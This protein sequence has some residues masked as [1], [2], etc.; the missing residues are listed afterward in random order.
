MPKIV[1]DALFWNAEQQTYIFR[2]ANQAHLIPIADT[3][4]TRLLAPLK[5]FSFHGQY[6]HL[7]VRREV[8]STREDYWYAYR[9]QKKRTFKRYV[10]RS[11]ELSVAQLENIARAL[12]ID[13]QNASALSNPARSLIQYQPTPL[14]T[15]STQ[16]HIPLL[17]AKLHFPRLALALVSRPRLLALLDQGRTSPLTLLSAPAGTGKTTLV[18]QWIEDRHIPNIAWISLDAGDNDPARFWR[19]LITACQSF[20]P[21]LGHEALSQLM[22]Y[23]PL[24][25]F[26]TLEAALTTFLNELVA[27]PVNCILVLEDYHL[28]NEPRIHETVTFFLEHLPP[29]LHVLLLSRTEPPL[30]LARLRAKG[31]LFEITANDLRFSTEEAQSFLQQITPHPL[32][33][34]EVQ[35]LNIRLE[36]WATGLRLFALAL[37]RCTTR[38]EISR[39]L[40]TFTGN[41]RPLQDY[42][43]SEVLEALPEPLQVFLLSTS[44][45]E[46]ATSSLCD[47]VTDRTD[48]A[49][50]L[51][52][53][54]RYGLF[55]ERLDE[56]WYRFHALFAETM[57]TEAQKR[58]GSETMRSLLIKAGDWYERHG[59]YE[60][61]I[62]LALRIGQMER[63]ARLITQKLEARQFQETNEFHTLLHWLE[64]LPETL[65][66]SQPLLS[67]GHALALFFTATPHP[68]SPTSAAHIEA[69]LQVAE[70]GWSQNTAALGKVFA[71]R[72][73]LIHRQGRSR[74]AAAYARQALLWLS[75]EDLLWRSSS[76]GI[77][78]LGE[79][80]EG[81]YNRAR[82]TLQAAYELS[83]ST[84][85]HIYTRAAAGRLAALC[86]E[87]GELHQ[88]ATILRRMLAEAQEQQDID[89]IAHAQLGL[90]R[91]YYEWNRLEKAQEAVR[92]V[93]RLTPLPAIHRIQATLLQARLTF[94]CGQAEAALQQL[95]SLSDDVVGSV[96]LLRLI[97][98]EKAFYYVQLHNGTAARQVL[99]GYLWQGNE[100]PLLSHERREL[101]L[102]RLLIAEDNAQEALPLLKRLLDPA[103]R[104]GRIRHTFEI[105]VLLALAYAACRQ[106]YEARRQLLTLLSLTS[107]EGYQ[108]LFL[109]E[110]EPLL[111]LLRACMT[112]I[113]AR[114]LLG[115]VLAILHGATGEQTLTRAPLEPLSAQEL[116]VLRLLASGY[117][118]P[119]IARALV[120]SV[121]TI[122]SQVQSIYRK[123]DV[124]NRVAAGEVARQLR[125]FVGI[126]AP[127]HPDR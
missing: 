17:E 102:A 86:F 124:H 35:Q 94:A 64:Q 5:T 118:N 120:V 50:I 98:A 103:Q 41:H 96:S 13:I 7:T 65:V 31:E 121:N 71:C 12:S 122:R 90:A 126:H 60:E 119:E 25:P 84:G 33:L 81:Q 85:N 104:A 15:D 100:L 29:S 46:Q 16:E 127:H 117:S 1:S 23:P 14:P 56:Q 32:A 59:L 47:A 61:A 24:K 11:A 95:S 36:G 99:Q 43:V 73:L 58:L 80:L 4:W 92:E 77:A 51:D 91:I 66:R 55:L 48:S 53:F 108:R 125:L 19:Y 111:A 42:F 110:G 69:L 39:C 79:T 45:L 109:D 101:L 62:T 89:D 105:Q 44:I 21:D 83:V 82:L 22:L 20:Q 112:V 9:S 54:T 106:T 67:F 63:A 114:P 3:H 75:P 34:E 57:R 78:G 70:R 28:L 93:L 76:M 74:E 6:G 49:Q 87:Q 113:R 2:T 115:S 18:R 38:E 123:L 72:A 97:E 27:L 107:A 40:A 116:R 8:R 26:T 37:Q 88:A 52:Q 10:G 30:P 68:L